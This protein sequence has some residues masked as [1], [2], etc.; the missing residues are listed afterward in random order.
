MIKIPQN[1]Y[2]MMVEHAKRDLPN[3]ACGYLAGKHKEVHY[4]ICMTNTDASCEHFSFDPQEQFDA[5]KQT[6]KEGLQL[7]GVYHS[8]P[9]TPARPSEEDIV[10]A[11]DP[12]ISYVIISLCAQ[13][14]DMKSFII[15][16]KTVEKEEIQ[17]IVTQKE[18][19]L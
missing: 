9:Q 12:R 4:A 19:A 6:Q 11:Y 14:P 8:H 1:V 7:I 16:N 10:L 3:E 2:E 5:F 18:T 15:Q 13:E 17:I